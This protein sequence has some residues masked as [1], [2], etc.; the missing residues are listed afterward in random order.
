MSILKRVLVPLVL[1]VLVVTGYIAT[2]G[3]D[4]G[5]KRVTALFPRTVSVYEGS[6]VRV[7]GVSVGTVDT[8]TPQGTV[9][10]VDMSYDETVDVPETAQAVIVSPAVV[11]D[12]YVQLTPVY[13]GGGTLSDGAVLGE[14]RTAVP[15]EL[16][17]VFS[18][19][20]DLTVALGPDGA[21][22]K[23][24]LNDLLQVTAANFGGQGEQFKT[25][26][27][28]FSKLSQTLDNNKEELFGAA[29]ELQKF[30]TTLA[31]NDDVVRDFNGSLGRVSTA[32]AGE[33]EELASA[34][35]NLGTGLAEVNEFVQDNRD[36]LGRDI[37]GLNRVAKVLV[38]R[39]GELAETLDDAPLALNNLAL[40]YNPQ[41]GT[42]DTNSNLGKAVQDA[43]SNPKDL[44]CGL[45]A[46]NDSDG[47]LC[48]LIQTLPLP[49]NSPFQ[50]NSGS[51]SG[52]QSD[53]T[54]GG[55]VE[56]DQ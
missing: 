15:L 31:D 10:K 44:L 36:V 14:G 29:A 5:Q 18:N 27:K 3:G 6:E 47:S 2:F 24:A 16:D 7:L 48:D 52:A 4:D 38:N 32:L 1:V 45:L 41:A 25:T 28:N 55:L 9:V 11:G 40:T 21:N 8:V 43:V 33:R 22:S 54:L 12:R 35:R 17:D 39:R 37:R 20:D 53:P 50:P 51:F 23:G 26:I 34:L 30:I 56:V 46:E 13:T 42:L 49:R 19:I